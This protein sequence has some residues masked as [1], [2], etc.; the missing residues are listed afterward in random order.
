ML[1]QEPQMLHAFLDLLDRLYRKSWVV[2]WRSA[3]LADL[4][5]NG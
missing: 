4:R 1:Q 2:Y 3:S 5:Y